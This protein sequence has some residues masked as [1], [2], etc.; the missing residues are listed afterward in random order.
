MT[1]EFDSSIVLFF[2]LQVDLQFVRSLG[3]DIYIDIAAEVSFPM[4]VKTFLRFE[5]DKRPL[6]ITS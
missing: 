2:C 5:R 1:A 3:D 6:L 4:R